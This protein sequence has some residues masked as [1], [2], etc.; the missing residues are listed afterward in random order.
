M[1]NGRNQKIGV[2]IKLLENI[3]F[4]NLFEEKR[5]D[6]DALYKCFAV[7]HVEGASDSNCDDCTYEARVKRKN[8]Q[9]KKWNWYR[10]T[11]DLMEPIEDTIVLNS[12]VP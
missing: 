1:F 8:K 12:S 9:D 3:N 2:N 11:N 4:H 10:F 6:D 7:V 5:E